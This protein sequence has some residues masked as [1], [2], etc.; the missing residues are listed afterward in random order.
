MR[1]A[2]AS[3]FRTRVPD[4]VV[5]S[6]RPVHSRRE[7]AIVIGVVG[8]LVVARSAIF[9]F[10]EQSFFD[11]DQA[12][13]GLMAKHLS[14]LRA[15][16]VFMYGQNYK[17]AVEAWLAAPV[18]LAA[19]ASVATLKLPLLAI[20]LAVAF[21]LLWILER[22]AHLRPWLAGV[23]SIFFVL[24]APGTAASFLEA[25]GGSLEPLLYVLLLW[26]TRRR[27]V[28]CGAILA[29]GFLHREFTIYG[30]VGLAI[31]GAANRSLFTKET[32]RRALVGLQSFVAVWVVIELASAYGSAAGP[33]TSVTDVRAA[34]G[35]LEIANRLCVD[36]RTIFTG[37]QKL[38]TVHWVDLF[39]LRAQPVLQY[40]IDSRVSQGVNGSWVFLFGAML[41]AVARLATS[42]RRLSPEHEVCAYVTATGL[43]SAAV[44]AVSRC[45]GVAAMR[46]DTLSI[47]AAVGIAGWYLCVERSRARRTMWLLLVAAWV[48]VSALGHARLWAEYLTHP[49]YGVKRAIVRE[50]EARSVRYG[51]SDY[52]IA[53]YVTFLTNERVIMR[54]DDFTR[55]LAYDREVLAHSDQMVTVARMPCPRG[56]EV[57]PG[58]YF[59]PP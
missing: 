21:L 48:G 54:S 15:F 2:W 17:L 49:P 10:W 52:W 5:T 13:I 35:F 58:V 55:I 11:S 16:P 23:A 47:L 26:I 31:V 50:L 19:G 40:G 12:V 57:V 1:K 14:E 59:C 37:L 39:G 9:V 20:N 8:L 45:G 4:G 56:D 22:D 25:G 18:F 24:P 27:P 34:S 43:T 41:L 28:W 7:R 30:V 33:S 36:P 51:S 46:Y 3:R 38:A 44:F 42:V 53:Y 29:I 6:A 32:L